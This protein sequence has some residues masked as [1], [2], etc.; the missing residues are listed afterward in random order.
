MKYDDWTSAVI[1]AIRETVGGKNADRI[2]IL[3]S[4][5]KTSLHAWVSNTFVK[6]RL[7]I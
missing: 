5:E 7:P 1:K 2:I 4:P 3:G 6:M